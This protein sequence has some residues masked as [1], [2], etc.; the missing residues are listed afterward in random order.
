MSECFTIRWVCIVW[1][2]FCFGNVD[3]HRERETHA[4][5]PLSNGFPL[6]SQ[7]N[8]FECHWLFW[9]WYLGRIYSVV[10]PETSRWYQ[11]ENSYITPKE[12]NTHTH[13]HTQSLKLLWRHN[14]MLLS[15]TKSF[16]SINISTWQKW[17]QSCGGTRRDMAVARTTVFF[18]G[19][20]ML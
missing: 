10:Y 17:C 18:K 5:N 3:I 7:S 9:F 12:M 1:W 4:L 19:W 2:N 20:R 11:K 6:W 16:L 15:I 14:R 8:K 13:T